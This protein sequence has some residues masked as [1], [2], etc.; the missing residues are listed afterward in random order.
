[1]HLSV[2]GA[3]PSCWCS[4]QRRCRN[5]GRESVMV[6][7]ETSDAIGAFD[8]RGMP[9][10]R[11]IGEQLPGGPFRVVAFPVVYAISDDVIIG[12]QSGKQ[13]L[14]THESSQITPL[15]RTEVDSL[16]MFFEPSQDYSWHTVPEL[17]RILYGVP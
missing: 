11:Q 9:V 2:H 14:L 1:M 16:G 8:V 7:L 12:D 10:D 15:E 5:L 3:S 6:V 13:Y 4:G 17:R